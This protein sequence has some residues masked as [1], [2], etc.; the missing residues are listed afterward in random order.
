ME[1]SIAQLR[2]LL[3]SGPTNQVGQYEPCPFK[4]GQSYMIRTVTMINLG[5]VKEIVGAFMVLESAG[6]VADTGRYHEALSKGTLGEFEPY[7]DISIVGLGSIVDA[8]PWLFELP[9]GAK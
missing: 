6:W 2:E 5:R 3:G 7:P 8:Q 1:L 4:V 9:R